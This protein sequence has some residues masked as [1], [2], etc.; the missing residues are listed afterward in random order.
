MDKGILYQFVKLDLTHFAT[1]DENYAGDGGEVEISNQF[2]FAYD[3]ENNLIRCTTS[4]AF[5][6]ATGTLLDAELSSYFLLDEQSAAALRD[7]EEVV[8]PPGFL[9]QLASLSYGSMRGVIYAKT[10]DSPLRKIVLPPNNVS[11][12]FTSPLKFKKN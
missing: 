6:A 11:S 4:V 12:I 3:F 8:M 5:N 7:G 9:A 1:F 10:M 2:Q